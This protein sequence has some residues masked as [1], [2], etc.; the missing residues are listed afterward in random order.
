[1]SLLIAVRGHA[2]I[3]EVLHPEKEAQVKNALLYSYGLLTKW[4]QHAIG[5]K[6]DDVFVIGILGENPYPQYLQKIKE[7][8]KIQNLPIVIKRL[9]KP[10]EAETCHLLYVTKTESLAAPAALA[11]VRGRPILTVG[12]F[13]GELGSRFVMNF[14]LENGTVKFMLDLELA[15]QQQLNIDP[16]LIKMAKLAAPPAKQAQTV[17]TSGKP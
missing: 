4:P 17:P 2:Q 1:M 16:R 10:E 15:R 11:K 14:Y 7:T 13:E 9:S 8:K 5:G 6:P 12:E 3:T